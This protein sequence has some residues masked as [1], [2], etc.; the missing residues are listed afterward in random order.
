[1]AKEYREMLYC[2]KSR[3]A[4]TDPT[5]SVKSPRNA[6]DSAISADGFA[7]DDTGIK[8]HLILNKKGKPRVDQ[9]RWLQTA[10][11]RFATSFAFG[12]IGGFKEADE[13]FIR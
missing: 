11:H 6:T 7:A 13:H 8:L 3:L 2:H 10:D 12:L 1:M 5:R 4:A 9:P